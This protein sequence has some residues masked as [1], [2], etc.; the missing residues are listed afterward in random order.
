MTTK[1]RLG[2]EAC[3]AFM[4]ASLPTPLGPLITTFTGCRG[5]ICTCVVPIELWST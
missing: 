1:C 3:R 4:T 2:L 5:G